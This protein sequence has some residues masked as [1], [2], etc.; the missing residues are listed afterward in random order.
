M[1]LDIAP[2]YKMYNTTEREFATA[3]YHWFFL[4]QPYPLPETLISA[5]ADF[6]LETCLRRWSGNFAAFTPEAL[7]EYRRCW[8]RLLYHSCHL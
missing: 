5:N 6:F 8:V 4:I 3:D 1:L 7:A 2:T